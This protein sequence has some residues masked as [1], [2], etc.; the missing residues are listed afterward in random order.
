MPINHDY[1]EKHFAG[2]ES[3]LRTQKSCRI[4]SRQVG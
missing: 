1:W 3:L 2:E 4:R